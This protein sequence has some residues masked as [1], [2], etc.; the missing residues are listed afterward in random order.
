MNSVDFEALPNLSAQLSLS[1]LTWDI[2]AVFFVAAIIFIFGVTSGRDKMLALLLAL[3]A[4]AVIARTVPSALSS[5]ALS[6]LRVSPYTQ[7]T[8]F[9]IF[10]GILTFL[11]GGKIFYNLFKFSVQGLSSL[12]QVLILTLLNSGLFVSL[13]LQFLPY[14]AIKI[15]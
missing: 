12:W 9:L 8:A 10:F 11:L 6:G 13:V 5:L 3:Y 4:G 1:G 15:S 2:A 14:G 7:L